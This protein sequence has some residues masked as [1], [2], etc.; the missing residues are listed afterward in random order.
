MPSSQV[1]QVA[2]VA[3]YISFFLTPAPPYPVLRNQG[4]LFQQFLT[5]VNCW[6][7]M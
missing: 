5:V 1:P 4:L 3:R 2:T 6:K 7:I